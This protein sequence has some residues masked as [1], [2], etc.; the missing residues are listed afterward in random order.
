M[1]ID[2]PVSFLEVT[3]PGEYA[4]VLNDL[5]VEPVPQDLSDTVQ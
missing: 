5:I 1:V 4:A 2:S 3:V